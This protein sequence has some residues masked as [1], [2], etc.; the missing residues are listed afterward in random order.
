M[1]SC[2]S[3]VSDCSISLASACNISGEHVDG[4]PA[5]ASVVLLLTAAAGCGI[6]LRRRAGGKLC[7]FGA[8]LANS[9]ERASSSGS[10]FSGLLLVHLLR[11]LITGN[12]TPLFSHAG[13]GLRVRFPVNSVLATV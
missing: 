13:G 1:H 3:V 7:C 2:G 11:S 5:V 10:R 9:G 4:I 8:Q 6:A 12:N